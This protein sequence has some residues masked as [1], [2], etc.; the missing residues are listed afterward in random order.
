MSVTN[1][2]LLDALRTRTSCACSDFSS[3]GAPEQNAEN[4]WRRSR[5]GT[6]PASVPADSADESF[7]F[8]ISETR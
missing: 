2:G 5:V 7:L 1:S 6:W 4:A 8:P 3:D